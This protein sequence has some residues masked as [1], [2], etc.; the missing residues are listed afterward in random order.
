[1]R[2]LTRSVAA[3]LLLAAPL[4]A[5]TYE[6]GIIPPQIV[7]SPATTTPLNLGDDSTRRVELGFD[8]TYWGQVFTSAWVSSNG[9]VSFEGS[10][11]LCCNGE[12]LQQA[13]RNTIYGLWSDLVSG[14]NPYYARKDG[15][16]LFGWYDTS[17]YGTQNK[18]TFE[19]GLF[20][21]NKIQFNYGNLASVTDHMFTA[22]ITGPGADDNIQL[23]YGRDTGLLRNQSGILSWG[24]PEPVVPIDCAVTPM[25]PSCPP[26]MVAP[27]Q[28]ITAAAIATIQEAYAADVEVDRAEALAAVAEPEQEITVAEVVE[29]AAETVTEV[30]SVTERVAELV[31]AERLSPDQVAALA[32]PSLTLAQGPDGGSSVSIGLPQTAFG[33]AQTSGSTS[34]AFGAAFETTTSSSS[35]SSVAN[36]LEALNMASAP[37]PQVAAAQSDQQTGNSMAE[38]QGDTMAAIAAVPGFAAYTQVALQDRPDFYA[39]RDIYRNR[40]LRDA[41]FEMYR[42]TNMNTSKWQEMV[43]AQYGR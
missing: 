28:T 21:D 13:Q 23:F 10:S 42:M 34:S 24:S 5:Q 17:E 7:G 30:V 36:T 8:F 37:M 11:H 38:G 32:A 6:P 29:L 35:P 16:I 15:S 39:I 1:M 4:A 2:A 25:D 26:Q 14:S 33:S 12:P 43:D 20:D 19:I 27:V 9:F 40:R 18:F 31:A 41:N 22:G 3:S